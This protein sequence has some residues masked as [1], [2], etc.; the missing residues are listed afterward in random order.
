MA[1]Q[2]KKKNKKGKVAGAIVGFILVAVIV[3][4][5]VCYIKVPAF[6]DWISNGWQEF[7]NLF[8]KK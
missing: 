1:K 5:V 2:I 8:K 7:C 4:G 3:A 6:R